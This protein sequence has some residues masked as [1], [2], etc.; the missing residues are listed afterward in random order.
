MRTTPLLPLISA[1]LLT[2]AGG[3]SLVVDGKLD[4][5]DAASSCARA[6]DGTPCEL[7]GMSGSGV[8]SDQVCSLSACG[9]GLT[10]SQTGEQCDD[11]NEVS[12]DGCEP[13][14]CEFSCEADTD[15]DD[16]LACNGSETCDTS[17]HACA[18][19]TDAADGTT[20]TLAEGG[21]GEC[22]FGTCRVVGCGNGLPDDGEDCDDGNEIS[23]DGCEADCTLTC[24]VDEDCAEIDTTVCD[25]ADTC[26]V[27][28]NTCVGGELLDCDDGDPCT[29]DSCDPVEGCI[30][31]ASPY[32]MD[33]DGHP[34][35]S[36]GGD[37]CDDGDP[38]VY[39]GAEEL[40]DSKDN[41]CDGMEDEVAPLWYIDCDGDGFASD[42]TGSRPEC[43]MPTDGCGWTTTR[44]IDPST[45][46]CNDGNAQVRPDQNG[47]FT[48]GITGDPTNYDYD[49][50][51][52]ERRQYSPLA[53]GVI[54]IQCGISPFGGSCFGTSYMTSNVQCGG[55]GTLSYCAEVRGMCD[56]VTRTQRV[57]CN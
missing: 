1:L 39:E 45:T 28:T 15:C 26:D 3:C 44:P 30:N 5:K 18:P 17:T 38:T 7:E 42:T 10:D 8:C 19:G 43:D 32:D 53:P 54:I 55:T 47:W 25:G 57:G 23:N 51:G 21:D 4:D 14:T 37:D 41:D 29:D 22:R 11:G 24:V 35:E 13:G 46:D 40:C 31:D 27:A 49:C 33:E 56:R 34:V 48:S 6:D 16:S 12:G 52:V 2:S 36:C 9:D 50:D 20:C